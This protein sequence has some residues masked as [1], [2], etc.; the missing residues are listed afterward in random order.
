VF[1]GFEGG[2]GLPAVV[3][4]GGVDVDQI[5]VR[6]LEHFSEVCVAFFDS[7]G[8]ADGV[9]F[10]L[11]ALADGVHVCLRVALINGDEFGTEPEAD[12]GHIHFLVGFFGFGWHGR[13]W[14]R[15]GM[16]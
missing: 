16:E 13:T 2:D 6:I 3:W 1:A 11:G 15:G 14:L 5:D 10:G 12:D 4:N 7:K 9:E 8:I